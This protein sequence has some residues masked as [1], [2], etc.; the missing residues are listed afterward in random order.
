MTTK[1][2]YIITQYSLDTKSTPKVN[3]C[4]LV[5]PLKIINHLG[6]KMRRQ[7]INYQVQKRLSWKYCIS[8]ITACTISCS[9]NP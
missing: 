6:V 9:K 1:Y 7:E 8:N 2:S 3:V 4:T 5:G